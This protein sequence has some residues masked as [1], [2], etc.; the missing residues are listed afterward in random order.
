MRSVLTAN[1]LVDGAVV[2]LDP[3]D[4]WS[5]R[6]ADARRLADDGEESA[7]LAR[8]QAAVAACEVVEPYLVALG[9]DGKPAHLRER[10]RADGPTVAY[11]GTED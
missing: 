11:A 3:H 7:A 8:G 10:I 5:A 6:F 2:F 9:E 1:R 4:R